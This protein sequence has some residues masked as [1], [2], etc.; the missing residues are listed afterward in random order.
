MKKTIFSIKSQ[1]LIFFCL[2]AVVPVAIL[3]AMLSDRIGN[4]LEQKVSREMRVEVASA[5]ETLETY[6]EGVRRDLFSL[7][8][9][10]QRQLPMESNRATLK[11]IEEEFYQVIGAEGS[12]YQIRF[13]GIDGWEK[14]R[15]NN[16][17]GHLVVVPP[18]EYQFKGKRYYFQDALKLQPGEVYLSPLDLNIEH[19]KVEEPHRLVTRMATPV[20][21]P[22][23]KVEGIVI[24]NIFGKDLL[25]MLEPLPPADGS[26]LFLVG[27]NDYVE[28]CW[29]GKKIDAQIGA[30]KTLP[31]HFDEILAGMARNKGPQITKGGSAFFATAPVSVSNSQWWLVK[32]FPRSLLDHDLQRIRKGILIFTLVLL[33]PAAGLAILAARR[34]SRPV[35]ALVQFADTIANGNY[36]QQVPHPG[37]DE[38]GHLT[39][40]LNRMASSLSV[41]RKQLVNWNQ[42]LQQEVERQTH[43]LRTSEEK[44]RLIF[45]ASSDAILIM[46]SETRRIEEANDA[47]SHVYGYTRKELH[48]LKASALIND[49]EKSQ[50]WAAEIASGHRTRIDLAYQRRKDG[51]VFPVSISAGVFRLLDREKLVVIVRDIS[52]GKRIE[53]LKDE[54]LSG[55]SH[56]MRTPLTAIIGYLELLADNGFSSEERREYLNTCLQQTERLQG[57]IENLLFLQRLRIGETLELQKIELL[58]FLEEVAFTFAAR[59]GEGHLSIDCADTLPPVKVDR[60]MLHLALSHLLENAIRHSRSSSRIIL[61]AALDANGVALRVEDHG[62]GVSTELK[63]KIFDRFF[64]LVSHDGKRVGGSGLGLPL[65]KEIALAHGGD[66]RLESEVGGGSAFYIILPTADAEEKNEKL[67]EY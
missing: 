32:T 4:I 36:D 23:G 54:M 43:E 33:F 12:Y 67:A 31:E 56:E 9:F 37:G 47:A 10:L 15:I 59:Y 17:G 35:D 57:L 49:P 63:G 39:S 26:K 60:E 64:Q 51:S 34:F 38:F 19:G 20:A 50:Q 45:S 11:K 46:D 3:G 6:L 27:E 18:G 41:S 22:E 61:G 16:I 58:P 40:A 53:K 55:L 28:C 24:I 1:L 8:R 66:V 42:T 21:T 44:Y 48:G 62:V 14:L 52:E 30:I 5:S 25:K 2:L 65:V 29:V 13:I 7:A